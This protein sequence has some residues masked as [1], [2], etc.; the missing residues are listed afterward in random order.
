MLPLALSHSIQ[1]Y[2]SESLEIY[3]GFYKREAA[4]KSEFHHWFRVLMVGFT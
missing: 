1:L 2:E 3:D 4:R